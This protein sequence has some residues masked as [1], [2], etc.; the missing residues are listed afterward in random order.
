MYIIIVGKRMDSWAGV[1]ILRAA[2]KTISY[3][4]DRV[5]Y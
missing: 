5:I 3:Q 2:K 4:I 1:A